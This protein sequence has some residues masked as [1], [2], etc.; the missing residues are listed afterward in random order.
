[1]DKEEEKVSCMLVLDMTCQAFCELES[2]TTWLAKHLEAFR[3]WQW[4]SFLLLDDSLE[5]FFKVSALFDM[6][7]EETKPV[8]LEITIRAKM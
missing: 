2:Q 3:F 5:D 7:S 1:M 4:D 8:S 6:H